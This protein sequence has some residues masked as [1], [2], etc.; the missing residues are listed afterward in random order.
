MGGAAGG[1]AAA[2]AAGGSDGEG[3]SQE[4]KQEEHHQPPRLTL[5]RLNCGGG[6]GEGDGPMEG[7]PRA[8]KPRTLAADGR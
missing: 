7:K 8:Q 4:G 5:R 3:P 1:G 2:P 6:H